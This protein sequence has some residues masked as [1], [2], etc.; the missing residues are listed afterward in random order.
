MKRNNPHVQKML[1]LAK[2]IN[3]DSGKPFFEMIESLAFAYADGA[4][5]E[6]SEFKSL[7]QSLRTETGRAT[8]AE[9]RLSETWSCGELGAFKC[10]KP[11]FKAMRALPSLPT[12]TGLYDIACSVRGKGSFG[13]KGDNAGKGLAWDKVRVDA[14]TTAQLQAAMKLANVARNKGK[15]QQPKTFADYLVATIKRLERERDG[16]DVKRGGK[17]VTVPANTS[18]HLKDAIAALGKL[19]DEKPATR[20]RSIQGGKANG[21]RAA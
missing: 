9:N 6:Q 14:P 15:V 4:L 17:T 20:L 8:L 5:T 2:S 16:Y 21:K 12:M 11:L 7:I 13:D 10:V 3:N 1:N 19:K 18:A